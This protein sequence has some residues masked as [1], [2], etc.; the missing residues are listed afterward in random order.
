MS[1][2]ESKVYREPWATRNGATEEN[3]YKKYIPPPKTG[4]K[5]AGWRTNPEQQRSNG[6]PTGV[7]L[8]NML[9]D[10]QK[11]NSAALPQN[12]TPQVAPRN[13]KASY[14]IETYKVIKND[15]LPG[16]QPGERN[17]LQA[18][19]NNIYPIN[20]WTGENQKS[21]E[22]SGATPKSPANY[23]KAM[24]QPESGMPASPKKG[25]RRTKAAKAKP[26]SNSVSSSSSQSNQAP[27]GPEPVD[28]RP[29]VQKRFYEALTMLAI[30]DKNQG[31]RQDEDEPA[32]LDDNFLDL[33]TAKLRR[34]FLKSLAYLCDYD[35][36]GDTVTAIALEQLHDKVIYRFASNINRKQKNGD[37]SLEF[38]KEVLGTL[39]VV[40]RRNCDNSVSEIFT[41]AVNFSSERIKFYAKRLEGDIDFVLGE[42]RF[43]DDEEEATF[44][45]WL[46]QIREATADLET[47]CKLC[48]CTR[49]SEQ[50]R[51]L[52]L[53]TRAGEL[54]TE[55]FEK[56]HHYIGRLHHTFKAT[57]TVVFGALKL[58]ELFDA[59]E[60]LRVE[61]SQPWREPPLA[62]RNPSL[63]DLAGRVVGEKELQEL[64]KNLEFLD[65]KFGL[66]KA[67]EEKCIKPPRQIVHAE[68]LLLDLFWTKNLKFVGS[69]RYI[70]CSK[71]ACYC[72][73]LY[74]HEHPGDFVLP[75]SH[76]NCYLSWR[77]PDIHDPNDAEAIKARENMLNKM[78]EKVRKNFIRRIQERRGPGK[79]IPDSLSGVTSVRRNFPDELL[80]V[81]EEEEDLFEDL[82]R[83]RSPS[84]SGSSST[85]EVNEHEGRV[86]NKNHESNIEEEERERVQNSEI[87]V[88]EGSIDKVEG[89]TKYAALGSKLAMLHIDE[90]N[91]E[92]D[93]EGEVSL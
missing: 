30:L 70:A 24:F 48:Y 92:D 42:P 35:K 51:S 87:G 3:I 15:L 37:K 38:L 57:D 5:G 27:E 33:E 9:Q 7:Q 47:I 52:H 89:V 66:G 13:N 86:S 81:E 78:V 77:I 49:T 11:A 25:K 84:F 44:V 36:G 83:T 85:S 79:P 56:I 76:N 21:Y 32:D 71:Q 74:V 31:E 18:E 8:L 23:M 54:C 82:E 46:R 69:D 60:V 80:V 16:R 75:A 53:H 62:E 73:R 50:Y 91:S 68:I 26:R 43:V 29:S 88:V 72:C 4:P 12:Q 55:R 22:F 58:R 19:D 39:R 40:D 10:I 14:K 65:G 67:L 34:S 93:N 64:R 20:R 6:R 17:S 63:S 1:T 90:D 59:F 28:V 61:S 45:S 2:S 41:K